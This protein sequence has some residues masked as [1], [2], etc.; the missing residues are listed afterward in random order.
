MS[1]IYT[2]KLRKAENAYDK[3]IKKDSGTGYSDKIKQLAAQI[4][5]TK[6]FQYDANMDPQYQA[7]K[8][9]YEA[10]GKLA[11][12]DTLAQSATLTGGYGNSYGQTAGQAVYND[13]MKQAN[14]TIPDLYA[15]AYNMHN[16]KINNMRDNLSMYQSL[17]DSEYNKKQNNIANLLNRLQYYQGASTQEDE[18]ALAMLEYNLSQQKAANS[19]SGSGSG[20]SSKSS[21]SKKSKNTSSGGLGGG[22]AGFGLGNSGINNGDVNSMPESKNT[23]KSK[24]YGNILAQVDVK[25]LAPSNGTSYGPEA[26]LNFITQQYK[27][28]NIT[29]AEKEY[30]EDHV[31]TYSTKNNYT[32]NTLKLTADT[33]GL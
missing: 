13:Y 14:D 25:L 4:E 20:G 32:I 5:T 9:Q 16:D 3:A 7:I 6:D 31:V 17:E 2:K 24:N 26:A 29:E 1:N 21:G 27:K 15:A 22:T 33:L 18:K 19:G 28:G 11:M 8:K 30:L 23:E 10:A 12:K